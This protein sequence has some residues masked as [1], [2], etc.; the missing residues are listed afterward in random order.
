MSHRGV[1]KEDYFRNNKKKYIKAAILILIAIL[2]FNISPGQIY[3]LRAENVKEL[4]IWLSN[5]VKEKETAVVVSFS[6]KIKTPF[7][8]LITIEFPDITSLGIIEDYEKENDKT[9]KKEL[10]K[11]I[12]DNTYLNGVSF[13]E[14]EYPL[15]YSS[16]LSEVSISGLFPYKAEFDELRFYFSES[17]KISFKSSGKYTIKASILRPSE[18]DAFEIT[19][20]KFIIFDTLP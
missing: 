1:K 2:L 19:S 11:F 16:R 18:L 10:W 9:R 4:N 20:N 7:C 3:L 13:K 17:L 8:F 5:P 12:I 14:L 6:S 15:V